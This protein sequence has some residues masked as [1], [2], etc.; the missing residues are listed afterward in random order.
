MHC[1]TYRSCCPS[2]TQTGHV[3]TRTGDEAFK[4]KMCRKCFT[5]NSN[6][7]TCW[8]AP[9]H[10]LKISPIIMKRVT[11]RS[12]SEDC[13]LLTSTYKGDR[14]F[15]CLM[16]SE[17]S[18]NSENLVTQTRLHSGDTSFKYGACSEFLM[19][20]QI[21]PAHQQTRPTPCNLQM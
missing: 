9:K 17:S 15:K 13:H 20:W 3:Q 4:C 8:F 5:G 18:T 7:L 16:Y 2:W 12:H 14:Q 6:L 1:K 10:I 21:P 19:Q 11:K